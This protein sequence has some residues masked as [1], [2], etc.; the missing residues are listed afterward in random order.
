MTLP[1]LLTPARI[2]V[3]LRYEVPAVGLL[4]DEVL[5]YLD[6]D[7]LAARALDVSA[8]VSQGLREYADRWDVKRMMT[9]E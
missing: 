2:T 9:S 8:A 6:F 5:I 1:P 7:P 3:S 4:Q